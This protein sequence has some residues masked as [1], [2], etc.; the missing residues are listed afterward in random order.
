MI[1]AKCDGRCIDVQEVD[2][3]GGVGHD[4]DDSE[5]FTS[6]IYPAF[7]LITNGKIKILTP[8]EVKKETLPDKGYWGCS[9]FFP[10]IS[11][12]IFGSIII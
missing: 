10:K 7:Q 4:Y 8:E 3:E 12:T 6:S 11:S 2:V 9:S 5:T 1:Y